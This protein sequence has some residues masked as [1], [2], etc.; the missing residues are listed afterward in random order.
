[1]ISHETWVLLTLYWFV[2]VYF[3]F[4]I[5]LRTEKWCISLQFG[6]AVHYACPIAVCWNEKLSKH[7]CKYL[8]KKERNP[9]ILLKF[10]FSAYVWFWRYRK[11]MLRLLLK[12]NL[13]QVGLCQ[14]LT[15]KSN[16]LC[17]LYSCLLFWPWY[18]YSRYFS[19]SQE[20]WRLKDFH[21][22]HAFTIPKYCKRLWR[23]KF[24][25][26]FSEYNCWLMWGY[27]V[28]CACFKFTWG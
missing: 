2:T 19:Y 15:L 1:M 18:R 12:L 10:T 7:Y 14:L 4:I 17:S 5:S 26:E 16:A 21:A 23:R 22:F 11:W 25:V 6:P 9:R 24:I 3:V 8:I 13:K 27:D 28:A 20:M